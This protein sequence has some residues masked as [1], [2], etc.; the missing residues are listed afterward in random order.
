MFAPLS[1]YCR[2]PRLARPLFPQVT[3]WAVDRAGNNGTATFIV[4]VS[5]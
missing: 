3:C 1:P 2:P 5:R 4:F